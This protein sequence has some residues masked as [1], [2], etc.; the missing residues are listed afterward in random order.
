ML[1]NHLASHNGF[2]EGLEIFEKSRALSDIGEHL[3]EQDFHTVSSLVVTAAE[4]VVWGRTT[5]SLP[6]EK[7]F[8]LN[9]QVTT[10]CI[11][12]ISHP[13]PSSQTSL[14]IRDRPSCTF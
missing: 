13:A 8:T 14:Y 4:N 2:T 5:G 10:V 3:T 9:L 7:Q 6:H 11:S 1:H 12:V